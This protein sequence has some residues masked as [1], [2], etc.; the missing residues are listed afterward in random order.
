[1]TTLRP[2]GPN[3][4]FTADAN[5]RT[6]FRIFCRASSLNLIF[7]GAIVHLL[8]KLFFNDCDDVV[9]FEDDDTLRHRSSLLVRNIYPSRSYRRL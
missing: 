4:T 1:M 5:V 7:F 6:P 9:G 2:L 8:L 3:V